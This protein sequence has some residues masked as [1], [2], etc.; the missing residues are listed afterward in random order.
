MGRIIEF[1]V[2]FTKD[3]SADFQAQD[4]KLNHH[5]NNCFQG[6]TADGILQYFEG[7]S[8][9]PEKRKKE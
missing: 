2:Y 5:L 9:S 4:R 1:P 8:A 3:E 7:T 6:T